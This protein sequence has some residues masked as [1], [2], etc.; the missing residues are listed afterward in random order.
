MIKIIFTWFA[1]VLVHD[2]VEDPVPAGEGRHLEE[3]NHALPKSLEVVH[4]VQ[5]PAQF[6]CHEETHAKNG[7]YKHHKEEE[8][9]DVEEGGHGHGE[10][11]E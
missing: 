10:G 2:P 3:E 11:K 7:K 8:E 5:R 9:A 4:F 6:H 1:V